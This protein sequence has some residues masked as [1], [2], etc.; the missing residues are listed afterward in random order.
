MVR[1]PARAQ[2]LPYP[3]SAGTYTYTVTSSFGCISPSSTSIVINTQPVTPAAPAVGTITQPSCTVSTGSVVLSNL[4]SSV[5]WTLT[6]TP[7]GAT[8]TGSGTST[9][10]SGLTAGTFTYKVTNASGCVSVSSTNVIINAQPVTPVAPIVSDVAYCRN[11]TASALTATA[12]SGHTL[13]WYGTN[14][15]GG[16]G[17][18]TPPGLSTSTAGTTNFYVSQRNTATT[19]ESVRARIIVT[20]NAVPKPVITA[21]GMGT[22]NVQL[23]SSA[24]SGNQWFKDGSA[25]AGATSQTYSVPDDGVYQVSATA[26]GC[27]S[28]LSDPFT[29]LVTDVK[30]SKYPI[31]LSLFPVPAREALTI[32]LTGVKDNEITEMMVIDMAGRVISKQKIIGAERTLVIE[33]YPSGNYFLVIT[34]NSFLLNG[35]FIKN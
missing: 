13:L 15:T 16:T 6:R 17:G 22:G 11:A 24:S 32:Q 35:R 34:N 20:I 31:R 7:G 10:L 12:L 9:T 30:D 29:A 14:E 23:G 25:I 3:C 2:A 1:Q 8:S 4:P 21:T 19:C 28:D 26:Q 5:T 33:D 18:T 27:V